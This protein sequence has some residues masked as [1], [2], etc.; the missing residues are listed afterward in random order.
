MASL[1]VISLL[2]FNGYANSP[3]SDSGTH[4][5]GQQIDPISK[6]ENVSEVIHDSANLQRQA[7][8]KQLQQ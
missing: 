2:I 1:L 4:I 6:A 7:L 8:K 5:S 3:G